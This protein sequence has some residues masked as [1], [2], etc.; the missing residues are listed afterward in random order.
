MKLE[1]VHEKTGH[2]S[3]PLDCA[4]AQCVFSFGFLRSRA[5]L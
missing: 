3:I 5:C 2:E 1:K 4:I